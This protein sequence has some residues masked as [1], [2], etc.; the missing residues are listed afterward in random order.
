VADKPKDEVLARLG[1]QAAGA[2]TTARA[3]A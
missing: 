2:R 1:G 3:A